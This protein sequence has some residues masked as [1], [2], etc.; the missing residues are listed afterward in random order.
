MRI[1]TTPSSTF[2]LFFG[3]SLAVCGAAEAAA[4][5]ASASAGERK[6]THASLPLLPEA[7]LSGQSIDGSFDALPL[8]KLRRPHQQQ[9]QQQQQQEGR[10][11]QGASYSADYQAGFQFILDDGCAGPNPTILVFCDENLVINGV[12]DPSIDCTVLDDP[13][14]GFVTAQCVNNCANRAACE[15]VFLNS[16]ENEGT[17][18]AT[19]DFTCSG[20][21]PTSI[22]AAMA[23]L[24]TDGNT[25]GDS[26]TTTDLDFRIFHM[27]QLAIVCDGSPLAADYF[28]ECELADLNGRFNNDYTCLA[29]RN[30]QGEACTVDVEAV[31]I[32][33]DLSR[34][35][36][37]ADSCVTTQFGATYPPE[38]D[39]FWTISVTDRP[40]GFYAAQF[41][42]N[43]RILTGINCNVRANPEIQIL[44]ANGV[45]SDVE[46][47]T[48]SVTCRTLNDDSIRCQET[49]ADAFEDALSGV[50]YVSPMYM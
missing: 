13:I 37:A 11:L 28:M 4:A 26:T 7:T 41:Q 17:P 12:S 1:T 31:I 2:R 49:N 33:V 47:I 38:D 27:A 43:W 29:G 40:L 25:C 50:T 48:P 36:S 32:N 42:T 46:G 6:I 21:S 5:A 44:C 10:A 20:E 23:F 24:G 14:G 45:I 22:D 15:A 16:G 8:T 19:I 34:L 3:F 35:A 39:P 18:Y 30:C 9:Q